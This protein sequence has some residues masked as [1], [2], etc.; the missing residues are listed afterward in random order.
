MTHTLLIAHR[1]ASAEAPENT[2][3]A[4]ELAL[5]QGAQMI[6]FDVRPTADGQIVVFHD[7]TT[8][9]W[10]GRDRAVAALTLDELRRLDIGGAQTPTLDEV[11][12]W[13]GRTGI[14][15]NVELKAGGIEA[16][17]AEI[18]RRHGVAAQ[19]IVSSFD[20]AALQA[21][22]VAA[23]EL[24]LG[25]LMGSETLAPHVRLREAWPLPVLRR[26]GAQ[27]WHP[28]WQLP[29]LDQLVPR[30]RRAGYAVYVWTVDDPAV[31]RRLLRLSVDGIMTNRPALLREILAE[32][33]ATEAA[34]E[35]SA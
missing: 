1:G 17:V 6:E 14:G 32:W 11:C 20:F 21:M 10:D 13:A 8:V 12:A 16:A 22:R 15:L 33:A 30:V 18:I 24:K 28:S 29:L 4:F 9:R 31:M 2:L 23:P 26:L 34:G 5:E 25:A 3:P 35:R 7:D 19:V 27:A